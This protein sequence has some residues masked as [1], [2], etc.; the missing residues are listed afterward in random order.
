ML[1]LE[2]GESN[3]ADWG[4]VKYGVPQGSIVGSLL[5]LLYINDLPSALSTDD[6]LL[7][8]DD[9]NILVSGTNIDEIQVR[10]KLILN[11]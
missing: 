5:F 6:K 2:A 9:T 11:S 10:S 4:T 7:Y 1:H 3:S 8:V